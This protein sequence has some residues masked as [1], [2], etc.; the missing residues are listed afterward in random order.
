MLTLKTFISRDLFSFSW[1]YFIAYYYLPTLYLSRAILYVV[2]ICHQKRPNIWLTWLHLHFL[3][4]IFITKIKCKW[5][6]GVYDNIYQSAAGPL[7]QRQNILINFSTFGMSTKLNAWLQ[8]YHSA[9]VFSKW[10]NF[11]AK[12]PLW[13]QE[14]TLKNHFVCFAVP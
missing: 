13:A 2:W 11:G 1:C 6:S 8:L 9:S 4:I 14:K 12:T 10:R 7:R 3:F 5:D